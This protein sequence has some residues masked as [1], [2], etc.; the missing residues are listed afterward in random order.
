M[1]DAPMSIVH[2]KQEAVEDEAPSQ[3]NKVCFSTEWT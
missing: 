2:I 1:P 3:S